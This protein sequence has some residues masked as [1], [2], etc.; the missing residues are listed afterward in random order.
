MG[1]PTR[2]ASVSR[3]RIAH[4]HILTLIWHSKRVQRLL[5]RSSTPP[6]SENEKS[7]LATRSNSYLAI[8]PSQTENFTPCFV[9][10][11]RAHRL[12]RCPAHSGRESHGAREAKLS[13]GAEEVNFIQIVSFVHSLLSDAL[14]VNGEL[15]LSEGLHNHIVTLYTPHFLKNA[16]VTHASLE[17]SP[18]RLICHLRVQRPLRNY[19]ISYLC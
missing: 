3:S 8:T 1:T 11:L 10:Y 15:K 4:Y 18:T 17:Y 13:Q 12:Y 14:L 7:T 2:L 16:S 19:S 5:E 9:R 6:P